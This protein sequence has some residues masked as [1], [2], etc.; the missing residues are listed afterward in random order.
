MM[1]TPLVSILNQEELGQV[2]LKYKWSMDPQIAPGLLNHR[3]D[4]Y[5]FTQEPDYTINRGLKDKENNRRV[6]INR[7]LWTLAQ[8]FPL[9]TAY[10]NTSKFPQI[11]KPFGKTWHEV[12]KDLKQLIKKQLDNIT[13]FVAKVKEGL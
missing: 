3:S 6:Y 11:N 10:Y 7:I 2:L 4:G 13:E 8:E 9:Y 12:A 5:M 1:T